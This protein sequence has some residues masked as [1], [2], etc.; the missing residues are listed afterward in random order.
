MPT[1]ATQMLQLIKSAI[2]DTSV[3]V[4]LFADASG[5]AMQSLYALAKKHDMAHLL[6][7]ALEKHGLLEGSEVAAAAQKKTFT[8]IYRYEGL[9]Y[10]LER[11]CSVLERAKIPYLPL[12]GSVLR[13]YYPEPWMRT[14]C[15]IDVLVRESDLDAAVSCISEQLGFTFVARGAHDVSA[16]SAGGVHLEL[17]FTLIESNV[18]GIADEPL[19]DVWEQS[20]PVGDTMLYEM[21][22][23]LFYYYHVAHMAK[24]VVNGG[25]GVRPILDLWILR[26]RVAFD[27]ARRASLLEH[28]GLLRFAQ[29]AEALCEVWF[30]DEEH[31]ELTSRLEQYILYGGVYGNLSNRVAVQQTRSGGKFKYAMSRIWLPYGTIAVYYPVLKKHKWL[32]PVCQVRRWFGLLLGGKLKSSVAELSVNRATTADE[33]TRTAQFLEQLDLK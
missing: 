7:A 22:D 27:E 17:H 1:T 3:D 19:A 14:S 5:E 15:D 21:P 31:T 26:H 18:V 11:V 29:A 12:K 25:C 8:A 13:R 16:L 9:R 23:E 30:G 20:R 24:H 32:L 33:Q 2:T 28:G 4:S 10:E 6:G